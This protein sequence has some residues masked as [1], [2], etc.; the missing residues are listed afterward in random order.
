MGEQA[1]LGNEQ[2]DRFWPHYEGPLNLDVKFW[3]L[4]CQ[5]KNPLQVF[6]QEHCMR[7]CAEGGDYGSRNG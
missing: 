2:K 7:S 1:S 5:Q 4:P 6:E 3:P